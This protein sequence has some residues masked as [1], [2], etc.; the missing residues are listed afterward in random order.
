MAA[1]VENQP[2]F[3]SVEPPRSPKYRKMDKHEMFRQAVDDA[4]ASVLC[5][6]IEPQS[7]EDASTPG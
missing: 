6:E 7:E 1:V 5:K 3:T 2:Y 4:V